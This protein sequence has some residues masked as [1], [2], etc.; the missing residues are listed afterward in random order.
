VIAEWQFGELFGVVVAGQRGSYDNP[1]HKHCA[2]RRVG[3]AGEIIVCF[4]GAI[5]MWAMLESRNILDEHAVVY[6]PVPNLGMVSPERALNSST[7]N[8]C[9][10]CVAFLEKRQ[11]SSTGDEDDTYRISKHRMNYESQSR[12]NIQ[13]LHIVASVFCHHQANSFDWF[14]ERGAARLRFWAREKVQ[15][16]RCN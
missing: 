14:R 12:A 6:I 8:T 11:Q 5:K 4:Y 15:P 1:V 9:E 16:T 7:E 10:I 3:S 13:V 2:K